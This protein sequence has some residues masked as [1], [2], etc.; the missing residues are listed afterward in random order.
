MHFIENF[1]FKTLKYDLINK[2]VYYDIHKLPKLKKIILNFGSPTANIK[3]LSSGL[4]AFELI[5][6][7]KGILTTT[8]KSN[9]LLKIRKGN[10]TGCKL[11]LQKYNL[12]NLF[13]KTIFEVFPKLKNFNGFNQNRKIKK[14]A[15]SYEIHD[16]FSFSELE[17]HYYFFNNLPKLDV[18]IVTTAKNEKELIFILKSLQ[19]PLKK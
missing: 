19:F 10:P 17:G 7:Q 16:T 8:K 12:F 1:Y 14:N 2:F 13:R 4:L 5:A 9:I 3:Q 18:T 15:F 6:N 11:T